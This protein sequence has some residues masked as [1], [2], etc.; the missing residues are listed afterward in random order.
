MRAKN[1]K[2][3]T[4][5][6]ELKARFDEQSNIEWAKAL[7]STGAHVVYGMHKLK[8]HGKL[9]LMYARRPTASAAMSTLGQAT[10][11]PPPRASTPTLAF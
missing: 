9:L 7:E 8:V 11:T 2:Q 3:V 1:G 4:V 5:L 10:T 6:V